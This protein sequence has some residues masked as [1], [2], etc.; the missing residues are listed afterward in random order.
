LIGG[1]PTLNPNL[2][3]ICN[4]L[5]YEQLDFS[6]TTNG[7]YVFWEQMINK[8][9]PMKYFKG[10]LISLHGHNP[11]THEK[12]TGLQNSF[13]KATEAI[14]V[15]TS[16]GV[17]VS[18]STVLTE[19]NV[20]HIKDIY[21][22]SK[23]LGAKY[24]VFNRFLGPFT[25]GRPTHTRLCK[26]LRQISSLSKKGEKIR[27]GNCV[28]SCALNNISHAI[29]ICPAGRISIAIGPDGYVRP[30]L[31]TNIIVGNLLKD[32][33]GSI[34]KSEIYEKWR[35][36]VPNLCK[37]CKLKLMCEGGCKLVNTWSP[38]VD[39]LIRENKFI[40]KMTPN[41]GVKIK[42]NAKRVPIFDGEIKKNGTDWIVYH[43]GQ[44]IKINKKD[45]VVLNAIKNGLC[46]AE[47]KSKYGH[48]SVELII[49]LWR[50]GMIRW[51]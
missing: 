23:S 11:D 18:T 48:T 38:T 42:I 8:L 24:T 4:R 28:P 2:L 33:L 12:F 22:L 40:T 6:I 39:P 3:D 1:E 45:I 46:I 25:D 27:F 41:K 29:E 31:H 50:R 37:N 34:W 7:I 44:I 16:M 51:Q 30:C 14:K 9:L 21:L 35:D 19:W 49:D 5:N 32:D 43:S 47:F 15:A 17:W 10:F 13:K 26:A 20:D 36:F